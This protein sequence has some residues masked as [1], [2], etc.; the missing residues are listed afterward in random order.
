GDGR[1]ALLAA[2]HQH[3]AL[4]DVVV[5]VL[6]G[7]AEPRLV[8][9]LD[10]GDVLDQYRRA[11][12]RGDHGVLDRIDRPDQADAAHDRR[13]R[14]DV[15]G[16][17][18]NIDV[19]VADR[20]QQLRQRQPIRDQLV[21][22]DLD[23][24]GLGLAAPSG[25][26]DHA[27]HGA[28]A[29]L[30]HPV[31]QGLEIE[32]RITGRADQ[33]VAVDFTDGA[34]RRNLRLGIVEE[35]RKLRQT[36]QHLLQRLLVGEVEGE[37]QFDVGQAVQRNRADDVEVLDARDLGLQRKGDVALDFLRRQAGALGDDVHHRRRR[38]GIGL[39]VQLLERDQPTDDDGDEQA[40]HH[41]P[42]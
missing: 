10:G 8:A 39:D 20:L 27:W 32:H 33:P 37:L 3:D 9:N 25:D 5:V 42:A 22:I 35:R 34:Q 17:T 12:W 29:T 14:A 38:V 13:L 2:P 31:L 41:E 7:D 28:E 16:V 6:A 15:D 11:V 24:I 26:V 40:D 23:F 1:G 36:V 30:Q 4:N 18:A 19:G 21:E